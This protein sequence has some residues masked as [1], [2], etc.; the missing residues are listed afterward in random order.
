VARL[1]LNL[2]DPRTRQRVLLAAA[3]LGLLVALAWSR[4]RA[5]SSAAPTDSGVVG[6]TSDPTAGGD[7]FPS[8]S[9]IPSMLDGGGV[10]GVSP[11]TSD[12]VANAVQQGLSGID[13]G[14]LFSPVTDA[15]SSLAAAMPFA[16]AA[17]AAD[18]STA[19]TIDYVSSY[20][21]GTIYS[22]PSGTRAYALQ[23]A[24]VFQPAYIGPSGAYVSPLTYAGAGVAPQPITSGMVQPPQPV[25]GIAKPTSL[26]ALTPSSLAPPTPTTAAAAPPAY[27]PQTAG[28]KVAAVTHPSAGVTLTHLSNGAV[29][30]QVKGKTPYVV[31]AA[32]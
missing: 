15:V 8:S 10:S 32:R 14:G 24:G 21:P 25:S 30:E 16:T 17:P 29:I 4:S 18:P 19:P 28:V 20:Q 23:P 5:S 31:K 12:Q 1:H 22:D 3:A 27:T 6:A 9:G 13:W 11:V 2:H 26:P 7:A